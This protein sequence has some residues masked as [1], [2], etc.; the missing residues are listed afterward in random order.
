MQTEHVN[1]C[2]EQYHVARISTSKVVRPVALATRIKKFINS[3]M[4]Q[5]KKRK[6]EQKYG[7]IFT[8]KRYNILK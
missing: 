3:N 8:N 7:L 4:M 5:N 2:P 6:S 1:T